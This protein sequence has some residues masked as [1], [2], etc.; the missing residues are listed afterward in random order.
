MTDRSEFTDKQAFEAIIQSLLDQGGGGSFG[1]IHLVSV[2]SETEESTLGEALPKA[3]AIT[4]HI[5]QSRLSS[6][7][8]CLLLSPG[9]YMLVFPRLSDLEGTIKATAIS[10]EIKARLFGQSTGGF[11]VSVQILP[12]ARLKAR[13]EAAKLQAME[14]ILDTHER[15]T[16]VNLQVV[17]QPIWDALAQGVVGNR[18][19]TRREFHGHVLF[20]DAVQFGG[21]QDPLAIERNATLQHAVILGRSNKGLVF[22]PQV[23]ND[24]TMA[25]LHEVTRTIDTVRA[26]CP[27]GL[28][29]ELT[30]A[31]GSIGRRRLRDVI[32]ALKKAG[33]E[34][35][36]RV[37]PEPELARF[38]RDCG[39][40]YLCFNEAQAK[41]AAFTHS[42]LYALFAVVAHEMRGLGFIPCLWNASTGQDV[43][44]AE[45]VGFQLFSGPPISGNHAAMV[46]PH[47]LVTDKV[48]L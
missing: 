26:C 29:V 47:P 14:T 5:I 8:A 15:H 22:M 9:K 4:E 38:I 42:A 7:D 19:V 28:V 35:G 17:F 45:S 20:D 32:T 6:E 13:G 10:R 21:E 37:L 11:N 3:V 43:K 27:D 12:V 2:F 23:I 31:V 41:L 40:T 46:V 34:V 36:V 48:Y 44:R 30:G 25:D 39:A 24:H 33:A 16:A 1:K 18:V